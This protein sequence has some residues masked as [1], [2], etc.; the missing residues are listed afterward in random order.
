MTDFS[1]TNNVANGGDW[2]NTTIDDAQAQ[3]NPRVAQ[4]VE[5][6]TELRQSIDNVDAA[7]V[8]LLA[9]RFKYTA[10]V[11]RLKAQAGFAPEDQEREQRQAVRLNELAVNAGLDPSIEERYLQ[12]V[13]TEVKRRHQRIAGVGAKSGR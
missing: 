9:E 3:A 13:V 4:A 11:G 12:F 5:R 1:D 8:S 6:I 7:I 10:E 2:C